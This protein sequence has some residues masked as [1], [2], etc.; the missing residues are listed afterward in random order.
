[1]PSLA[2]VSGGVDNHERSSSVAASQWQSK[3]TRLFRKHIE[4]I[5][6]LQQ[7]IGSCLQRSVRDGASY[8]EARR[9]EQK[10]AEMIVLARRCNN[11]PS[12]C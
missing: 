5:E 11:V 1:M 2:T 3:M 6:H 10:I 9:S 12:N 7:E 4:E 8:K